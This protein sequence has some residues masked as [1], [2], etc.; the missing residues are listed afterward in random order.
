[1]EPVDKIIEVV[2]D[3]S[4]AVEPLSFGAPVTNVYNPLAYAWSLHE[5]Y[6]RIQGAAPGRALLLGMNP[7]PWGMGQTGVPFGEVGHVRDWMGL[8]GEVKR[9]DQE[10]P[11]RPVHGL[12][13]ARSE[14]SGRRLWGWAKGRY[15]TP[16][17]FF[18]RFAVW[19]HCPL[20]FLEETGRNRTPD[21]LPVREREP[22][23]RHCDAALKNLVEILDPSM[24]VGVGVWAESCA[25]RVV[26]DLVPVGRVLHPS[27]A[28]PAANRG[29]EEAAE[30]QLSALGLLD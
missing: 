27:P 22:L 28:S 4:A 30:R 18:E 5:A 6:L 21:K 23:M 8:Q 15:N 16:E 20:A 14:V 19:N 1:M 17:A 10:H 3:L 13:C 29:W 11:K 24:V 12:D 2:S 7:G 25:K 26:G 9:P